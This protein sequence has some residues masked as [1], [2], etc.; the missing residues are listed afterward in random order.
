MSPREVL[1]HFPCLIRIE[2]TL[3]LVSFEEAARDMRRSPMNSQASL[4]S[5]RTPAV[6]KSSL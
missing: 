3:S 2:A 5:N 6:F 1:T 4:F